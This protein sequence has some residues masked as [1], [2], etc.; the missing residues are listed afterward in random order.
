MI[1][2]TEEA[3]T[4][5]VFWRGQRT[6]DAPDATAFTPRVEEHT[7]WLSPTIGAR[8]KVAGGASA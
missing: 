5:L 6:A 4:V 3:P 7:I 1:A 2:R 8:H